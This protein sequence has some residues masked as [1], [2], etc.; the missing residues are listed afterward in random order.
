MNAM[1]DFAALIRDKPDPAVTAPRRRSGG[2]V[3]APGRPETGAPVG[4]HRPMARR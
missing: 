4:T 2:S 3:P 1:D